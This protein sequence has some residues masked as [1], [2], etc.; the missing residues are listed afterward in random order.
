MADKTLMESMRRSKAGAYAWSKHMKSMR[1]WLLLLVPLLLLYPLFLFVFVFSGRLSPVGTTVGTFMIVGICWAMTKLMESR[2]WRWEEGARGEFL[3]GEELEKL[4]KEGFHVFHDYFALD[5]GNVDHFVVGPPGV[6]AIETKAWKGEITVTDDQLRVDG[7]PRSKDPIA[8]VKGEA[9]DVRRL[10]ADACGAT[11]WV[12]P[13]VC[14]STGE[15]RHYGPV[16]GVE[17]TSVGSLRNA[18]MRHPRRRSSA[19]LLS[20]SEV[21]AVSRYLQ[22]HLG[23]MPASAPGSPPLPPGRLRRMMRSEWTYVTLYVLYMLVLSLI[24]AG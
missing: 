1:L 15:L 12:N 21:G 8:Q 7:Q 3:V 9:K 4:Y 24:F 11:Y 19:N 5:R 2:D 13:I 18:I 17:V 16:R 10:I 6:F 14:F 23:V 20:A 22:K